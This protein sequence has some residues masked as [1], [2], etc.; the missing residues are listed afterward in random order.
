[1]DAMKG[2]KIPSKD[3][4]PLCALLRRLSAKVVYHVGAMAHDIEAA[5]SIRGMRIK[6]D[7][8]TMLERDS[9]DR[10]HIVRFAIAVEH[11]LIDHEVALLPTLRVEGRLSHGSLE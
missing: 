7:Q 5:F 9:S 3:S 6:D 2:I 8:F 4:D 1:M 10:T 11:A